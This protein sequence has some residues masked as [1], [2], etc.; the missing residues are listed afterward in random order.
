MSNATYELRVTG[1]HY[2]QFVENVF[3]FQGDLASGTQP[4]TEGTDLISSF[5]NGSAIDDYR[6]CLPPTYTMDRLSA[7]CVLPGGPSQG[8]HKQV[9]NSGFV[10]TSGTAAA[11]ENLCPVVNLIPPM[12]V[13]SQGRIYMPCIAKEDVNNNQLQAGYITAIHFIFNELIAGISDS[14]TLWKLAIYSKKL[15]TSSL[16]QTHTL[17]AAI[18]FQGRRR[19][20]L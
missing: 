2:N 7:R 10:G 15:G 4:Y 11:S 13:K 1:T 14:A 3:H 5:V 12:G 8:A 20:P 6:A 19:K 9:I 18:G 16:V 17:S